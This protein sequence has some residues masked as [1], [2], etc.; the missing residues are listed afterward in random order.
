MASS[1]FRSNNTIPSIQDILMNPQKVY[2]DLYNNNPQ[3]RKFIGDNQGK[4]PDQIA[5][6]NGVNLSD[7]NK[8]R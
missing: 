6:E 8:L 3:F 7:I 5:R 1:L 2:N 4:T